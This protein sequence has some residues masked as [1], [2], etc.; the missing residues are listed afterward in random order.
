MAIKRVNLVLLVTLIVLIIGCN[1]MAD[2][3]VCCQDHPEVG[4][5][6]P[7]VTDNPDNDGKC[8]TF[9]VN[10]CELGGTCKLVENKHVC[11]CRCSL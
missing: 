4:P 10:E 8:W 9:C 11:H 7:G 5:C 1:N 2:A 3:S 6:V